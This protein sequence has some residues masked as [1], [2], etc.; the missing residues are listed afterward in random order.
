MKINSL[1]IDYHS[2][3]LGGVDPSDYPDFCDAYVEYA[4]DTSGR[5]L[6]D[7]ELEQIPSEVAQSLAFESLL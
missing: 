1:S 2:I 5:P 3:E 4:E 6:T 7:E